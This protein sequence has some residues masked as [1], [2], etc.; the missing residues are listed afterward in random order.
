MQNEVGWAMMSPSS[1]EN[2]LMVSAPHILTE[3]PTRDSSGSTLTSI[4]LLMPALSIYEAGG[5]PI[6][7]YKIESS[8]D[9]TSW[10]EIANTADSFHIESGLT[11]DSLFYFRYSVQN[12]VG[13][14]PVSPSLVTKI[15]T[16][17]DQMVAPV[18][19]F[20]ADPLLI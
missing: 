19:G 14:S 16:E 20:A 6:L 5:L 18:V 3:A 15:G 17:P 13:W 8:S 12:A 7:A 9:A 4:K 11:T 1:N 2:V 10:T